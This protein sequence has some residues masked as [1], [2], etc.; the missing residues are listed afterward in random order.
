MSSRALEE[1]DLEREDVME[2]ELQAKDA[3]KDR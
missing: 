3:E 2:L 1:N